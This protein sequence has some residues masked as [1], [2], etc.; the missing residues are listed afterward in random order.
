MTFVVEKTRINPADLVEILDSSI[1]GHTV[2]PIRRIA[3]CYAN[4]KSSHTGYAHR[5][6]VGRN[7]RFL[8][9]GDREQEARFAIRKASAS[10]NP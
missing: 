7:C 9:K 4:S 6:I 8:Q 10:T 5:G 3:Y 2:D 1:N